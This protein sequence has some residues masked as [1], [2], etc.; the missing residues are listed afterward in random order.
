MKR[1][2]PWIVVGVILALYTI[3]QV[4]SFTPAGAETDIDGYIILAKRIASGGPLAV[5]EADPFVCQSHV[6]VENARGEVIPKFA[7]G[8]PALMALGY[9]LLGDDGLFVVGPILGG[10]AL[11]GA[12]LLFRRWLD[13]L[14]A[15][16]A[17]LTL[18]TNSL[19][20]SYAGY[21]L[22][23]VADLCFTTWG[24]FFLW[25]WLETPGLATAAG[26]GLTLG[27]A[28][29]IRHTSILDALLVLVA[30]V[31][32]V[33]RGVRWRSPAFLLTAYGL[34]PLL[35]S[36]YNW[37][38]FGHPLTSG[39]G[40][41]GEQAAFS[42]RYFVKNFGTLLTGLNADGMFLLFPV[43]WLG[44]MAVGQWPN[45]AL[46]CLWFF[47]TL[48]IYACYYWIPGN[49]ASYRFLY[50]TLPVVIGSAFLLLSHLDVSRFMKL[51]AMT[52]LWLGSL[53]HNGDYLA[54]AFH[55]QLLGTRASSQALAGH[56]ASTTLTSNAVLFASHPLDVSVGTR[57]HYRQYSRT[58]FAPRALGQTQPRAD[59]PLTQASRAKRLREYYS[60][61]TAG[62]LQ[63]E[64]QE[65]IRGFLK[66]SR[67]VALL[68]PTGQRTAATADLGASFTLTPLEE[69]S[70]AGGARWGFYEVRRA[71]GLAPP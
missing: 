47:T 18:A 21:P 3:G 38:I 36:F 50:S 14:P 11:V 43:G 22:A 61:H 31:V 68:I 56:I 51:G 12:F 4:R 49:M 13:T 62:Q 45:R 46:R 60:D 34:F 42:L 9:R 8:Y 20:L 58:A 55:G 40:L 65:L 48:V 27:Y 5:Q 63:Q 52:A 37:S 41:T 19:F 2:V 39:Y 53:V 1:L 64:Q 57:E 7:P 69:F 15:L 17:L 29:T 71:T 6:W 10:L 24:M 25:R 59:T 26:A 23:H 30:I 44:L 16:F 54:A 28:C 67:Q 33:R 66:E 35:L 32:A 70:L